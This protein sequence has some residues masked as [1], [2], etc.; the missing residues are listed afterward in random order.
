[1]FSKH[2]KHPVYY[3]GADKSLPDQEANKLG[4]T[5]GTRAISTTSRRELLS[6]TFPCKA[7]SRK[8]IHAILTETLACFLPGLV[9][10]LSAPLYVEF[11]HTKESELKT[12]KINTQ[13]YYNI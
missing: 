9:K 12:L 7:R 8:K 1:M 3:R 10:D 6:S 5:S 4:I 11:A 2:T 13:L